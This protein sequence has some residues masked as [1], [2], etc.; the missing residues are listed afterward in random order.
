[1]ASSAQRDLAR[2][3]PRRPPPVLRETRSAMLPPWPLAVTLAWALSTAPAVAHEHTAGDVT[4]EHPH[5]HATG[6]AQENG[7]VCMVIRNGGAEP[8]RLLA[9]RTGEAQGAE[10]RRATI[11]AEGVAR[12]GPEEVVEIPPG[13]EADL[14]PSGLHVM[15]VGLRGPLFE[16]VSFPMTL[17]FE[18]AGEVDVEVEVVGESSH[19]RA[20]HPGN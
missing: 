13:G 17:V 4:I 14:S 10:L 7:T 6:A 11:F 1:M 16:G 15:L 3:G 5:A 18:R 9:A 12:A 19:A 8:E 20:G 2:P